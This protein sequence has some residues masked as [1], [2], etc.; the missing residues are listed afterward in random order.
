METRVPIYC[1]VLPALAFHE[2]ILQSEYSAT[3]QSYIGGNHSILCGIYCSDFRSTLQITILCCQFDWRWSLEQDSKSVCLTNADLGMSLISCHIGWQ[4]QMVI[5]SRH[6]WTA[7][8]DM[9]ELGLLLKTRICSRF[10]GYVTYP[11]VVGDGAPML[12]ISYMGVRTMTFLSTISIFLLNFCIETLLLPH[13]R[14]SGSW[15][16]TVAVV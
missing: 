6:L 5:W 13:L 16:G 9:F 12:L 10:W 3:Y 14:T 7:W 15:W 4:Q 1:R 11:D 8:R 2:Q